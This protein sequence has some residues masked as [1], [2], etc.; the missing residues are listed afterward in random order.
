MF[1]VYQ[2]R[3]MLLHIKES[4]IRFVCENIIALFV[5]ANYL[6]PIFKYFHVL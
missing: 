3:I 2:K 4:S 6:T 1:P 5:F